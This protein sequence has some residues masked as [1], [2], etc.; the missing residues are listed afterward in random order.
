IV[1]ASALDHVLDDAATMPPDLGLFIPRT[2]R[3]HPAITAFTSE[4]FYDGRLDGI[5]G[6]GHQEVLCEGPFAGAGLR[7]VEVSHEGNA[8]SSPEEAGTVAVI[9]D[10]LLGCRWRDM[11]EEE[12]E[13]GADEILVVTPFN[14]QLREIV[15]ELDGAGHPQVRVGTVDKFQG[16]QAPV[17]IYSMAS[18]SAE[19][20]PRGLAFLYDL[21]RLNVATSRARCIAI[22]VASPDLVRVFGKTPEQ[23]RLANALCRL[24]ELAEGEI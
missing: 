12:R 17:V 1:R 20:A 19:E 15:R 10:G 11:R 13:I 4:V 24:R 14:A 16:R 5:E 2:R 18:S 8:N 9:V 22:L 3:M 21:N 6:L 23:M 7:T